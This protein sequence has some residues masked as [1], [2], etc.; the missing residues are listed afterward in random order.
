MKP[1]AGHDFFAT[2]VRFAAVASVACAG[3]RLPVGLAKLE[4]AFVYYV[5]PEK[6]EVKIAYPDIRFDR[7]FTEVVSWR[8]DGR[9]VVLS[10][11]TL[12]SGIYQA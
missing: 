4:D 1:K 2:A 7:D 12:A 5:D 8:F 11:L 6:E 9:A 10:L 3:L